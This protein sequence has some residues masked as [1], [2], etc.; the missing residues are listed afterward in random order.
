MGLDIFFYKAGK[1]NLMVEN[2]IK[3]FYEKMSE[4]MAYDKVKEIARSLGIEDRLNIREHQFTNTKSEVVKLVTAERNDISDMMYFRKHN[5]LL[6][7]LGFEENCSYKVISKD[8]VERFISA[9]EKVLEKKDVETAE[10]LLPTASGCFFGNNE[11]NEWYFKD[12]EEDLKE[13]RNCFAN[14]DWDNDI[15]LMYCWW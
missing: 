7:F 6:P 14:M 4:D 3:D 5:W 10:E 9:A 2:A 13:F 12:V 1:S 11:Y 15:L 8:D